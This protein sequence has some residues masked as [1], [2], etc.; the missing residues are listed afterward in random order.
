VLYRIGIVPDGVARVAWRYRV[1]HPIRRFLEPTARTVSV[2]PQIVDNIAYAPGA[3]QAEQLAGVDWY[4]AD[5]SR[6]PT[7]AAPLRRALIY[8]GRRSSVSGRSTRSSTTPTTPTGSYLGRS[9][10]SASQARR[11]WSCPTT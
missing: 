4:A 7:S 1:M 11:V 10:C 9:R 6:I 5:G 8:I 3:Q 2:D